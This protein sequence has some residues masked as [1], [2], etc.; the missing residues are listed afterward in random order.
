MNTFKAFEDILKKYI[1]DKAIYE[2][3]RRWSEKTR[4]YH[5]VN[6]LIQIIEDIEIHPDFK[7]LNI[8]EKHALLL[9]AFF[10]DA[11]L[12]PR[13]QDNEDKSIE[14]FVVSFKAKDIKMLDTVCDLIETTKHRVRPINKLQRIFWEADNAKFKAGYDTLLKNEKLIQKEYSFLPK[15]KYKENRIKFVE[16]NF[17]LFGTSVDKDLKKLLEFI[18]KL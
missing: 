15:D 3:P 6:H 4:F 18:K 14:L 1:G 7:Y 9:A 8:Y 2:L 17:G 5:S 16:S 11:I 13:R 12:N 10:H